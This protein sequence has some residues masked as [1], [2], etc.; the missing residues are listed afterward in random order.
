VLPDSLRSRLELQ[1][2]QNELVRYCEVDTLAMM[3]VYQA[4]TL[5]G[6]D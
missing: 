1:L 5:H 6:L 3:M 4:L 2:L